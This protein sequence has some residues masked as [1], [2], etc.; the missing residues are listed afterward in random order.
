[1]FWD[2]SDAYA[3]VFRVGL[4]FDGTIDENRLIAAFRIAIVRH[5]LLCASID[6][7]PGELRWRLAESIRFQYHLTGNFQTSPFSNPIVITHE[8]G[9]RFWFHLTDKRSELV[10]E[11]HHASSDAIGA[12]LFI[13]DWMHAYHEM[14][15]HGKI[16][17]DLSPIESSR[18][19]TRGLF[20]R[21]VKSESTRITSPWEKLIHAWHFHFRGPHPISLPANTVQGLDHSSA[22]S[23][24]RCTY[25]RFCLTL[26]Q[27]NTF[28]ELARQT[29]VSI[30]ELLVG[31]LIQAI[32]Q[33]NYSEVKNSGWRRAR[34]L[35]PTSH[36]G[37]TELK[38]PAAN[39]L[40]F[41]FVSISRDQCRSFSSVMNQTANQLRMIQKLQLGL[42]FVDL[43]GFASRWAWP[44][45]RLLKLRR[46]LATAVLT[47][48][49]DL[50]M[51]F[52]RAFGTSEEKLQVG[53]LTLTAVYGVPP[54]RPMTR[55]GFGVCRVNGKLHVAGQ[56]VSIDGFAESFFDLLRLCADQGCL[57]K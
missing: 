52:V 14:Q 41:G 3:K 16:R 56:T 46:C 36:R 24:D 50:T 23:Q 35:I 40:G 15:H 25:H 47:N 37:R 28:S 39:R 43:F 19:P 29:G 2:E 22:S 11:F 44:T 26:D 6:D 10:L 27:T 9:L 12:R 17:R 20:N 53:D 30:N 18:L 48:I 4:E 5:A 51:R 13:R 45:K 55:A 1:M 32:H 7:S 21:P 31:V 38:L 42:D 8:P 49:G 33:W 34:I 57:P 54:I